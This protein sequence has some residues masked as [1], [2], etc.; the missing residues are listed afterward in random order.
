MKHLRYAQY[1]IYIF[2][3]IY[4]N[5]YSGTILSSYGIGTPFYFPTTQSMGLGG[6]SIALTNPVSINHTNPAALHS[7]RT[8]RL[9]L[10]YLYELNRY[11]DQSDRATSHYSNF[12]GFHF[13]VPFGSNI[14]IASGITPWTRVDYSLL[15]VD[16]SYDEAYLKTVE[17]TGGLNAFTFSVSWSIL[18]QMAV[19]MTGNFIFGTMDEVWGIRYTDP[20]FLST[21]DVFSTRTNGTGMTAGILFQPLPNFNMAG[22]FS[23]GFNINTETD[24]TYVYQSNNET[25]KGSIEY[26]SS[27]G[28][29]AT[30][31]F[32]G[33]GLVGIDYSNTNWSNLK[34]QDMTV[35]GMRNN[36]KLSMGGEILKTTDPLARFLNRIAYRIGYCHQTYHVNDINGNPIT[37]NWVSL[38]LGIPLALNVARIDLALQYG[39][40]GNLNKSGLAENLFRLSLGIS[41]GEKWFMKRY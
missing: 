4:M 39:K 35:Q 25:V 5:G 12:N 27:W 33:S 32:N 30:Y 10:K 34:I 40:R 28:I 19:G 11:Q 8:T 37:E 14:R 24:I 3:L 1:I 36:S 41:G 6:V 20:S 29:G 17:G 9:S 23:P 13:T 15:I 2:F 18:P 31:K 22:V 38:G 16:E 7:L 21:R 26:P